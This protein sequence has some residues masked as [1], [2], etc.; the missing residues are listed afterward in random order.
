[1]RGTF[2]NPVLSQSVFNRVG[3]ASGTA[4]MTVQGTAIKTLVLVAILMATAAFTWTQT[5][6]FVEAAKDTAGVVP[7]AHVVGNPYLF[8]FGGLIGGS[9][10]ALITWL[11]P[12]SSPWTAPC[13]AGFEGLALGG[14]SALFEGIYPGIVLNAV[15]LTLGVLITM[16]VV[17]AAGIIRV[18]ERF[19]MMV[20]SAGGAIML[21]YFVTMVMNWF[22]V[23]TPYIHSGLSAGRAGLISVGFSI[24]CVVV[25]SLYLLLDFEFIKQNA[26]RGAPRYMEWY[27]GFGLLLTLV[28]L[29]IEILKLL[30]KLRRR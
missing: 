5:I 4:T 16:L 19:Q 11:F 24:V 28:W 6:S 17:Y 14:I 1:M 18:T 25:A 9:I 27:S 10:F 12:R 22:G 20:M 30:A 23:P 2:S 3:Y 8:V 21:V 29:Y 15:G 7:H 13:Y 26:E